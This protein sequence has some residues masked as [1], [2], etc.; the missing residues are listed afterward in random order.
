MVE[1]VLD[2]VA[3]RPE[4]EAPTKPTYANLGITLSLFN[5][6]LF[7]LIFALDFDVAATRPTSN[8]A[9]QDPDACLTKTTAP[10][11]ALPH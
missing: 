8:A 9:T 4:A 1:V 6:L 2:L 5:L 11:P 3:V 7:D 10:L